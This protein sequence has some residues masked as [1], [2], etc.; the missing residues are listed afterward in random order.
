MQVCGLEINILKAFSHFGY[1]W[2]AR[3]LCN[4]YERAIE[5][6]NS[7]YAS[8][9]YLRSVS[10]EKADARVKL[11]TMRE[12]FDISLPRT[13]RIFLLRNFF[14][15]TQERN[16]LRALCCLKTRRIFRA[17]NKITD[18]VRRP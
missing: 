18:A 10:V 6:M 3:P 17:A 4:L 9:S 2:R 13:S 5:K 1:M 8:S 7:R 15:Y 11:R 12:T 16:F 14:F